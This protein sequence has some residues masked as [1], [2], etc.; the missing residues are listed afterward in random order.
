MA[1]GDARADTVSTY[2]TKLGK[3]FRWCHDN[4]VPPGDPTQEQVKLYRQHLVGRGHSSNYIHALLNVVRRFYAGA[5]SRGLVE[6][7]PA[8][9]VKPPRN[10]SAD[11]DRLVC[12][13]AGEAEILFRSLP[14]PDS[15]L[16]AARDRAIIALMMLEGLR[17]VEIH[18]ANDGD[19][20]EMASGLR[21]LIHGKGK[22]GYIYP[23]EDVVAL[24]KLYL[25]RRGDVEEDGLG[26]PMFV[27]VSKSGKPLGRL[28]RSGLSRLIE[29]LF[30]KAAINRERLS[31]HALRHT[32]GSQLYQATRDVKVVQETLR[33]SSIAM[34]AKYSHIQDRGKVRYTQSIPI[35]PD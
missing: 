23:R 13:S 35:K 31:C 5:L 6:A 20:E 33:H 12:L 7:N 28:T 8:V 19:I 30:R 22:E 18:R 17:R 32:C 16:K 26:R 2:L 21:L 34:A 3:W 10:R 24:L 25:N 15:G 11:S 9:A 29:T 1:N 4:D 27:S 14:P